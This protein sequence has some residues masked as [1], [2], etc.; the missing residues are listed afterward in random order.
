LQE[1]VAVMLLITTS[2][3]LASVVA[4]FAINISS[5]VADPTTNPQVGQIHDLGQ[6]LLNQT[7]NLFDDYP[8]SGNSTSTTP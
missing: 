6:Q 3:M 5:S 7:N 8:N 2:V 4:G 1:Q